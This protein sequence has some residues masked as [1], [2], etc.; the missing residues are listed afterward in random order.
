ME[1]K[2]SVFDMIVRPVKTAP[3]PGFFE[4]IR[5]F[6]SWPVTK[7]TNTAEV[8]KMG[9]PGRDEIQVGDTVGYTSGDLEITHFR[10]K[11]TYTL[12]TYY[13]TFVDAKEKTAEA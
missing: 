7:I 6:F 5:L 13:V 4:G 11:K 1:M 3:P 2:L 9:E 10:D 8:L 12:K